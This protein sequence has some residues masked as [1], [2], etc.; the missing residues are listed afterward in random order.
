MRGLVLG[1]IAAL[2]AAMAWLW[3][4]PV[5]AG[6]QVVANE[7]DCRQ[8]FSNGFCRTAFS[9]TA[10]IAARSGSVYTTDM[11]CRE[12]WPVC[13][14]RE[15]IGFGPRPSHWCLVKA[16]DDTPARIEPQYNNR[17]Q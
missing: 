12:N 13:D 7:A 5:C 11:E 15:P 2:A 14:S 16:A 9:R 17:R 4:Q 8:H 6:G 1:L 3:L 10:A